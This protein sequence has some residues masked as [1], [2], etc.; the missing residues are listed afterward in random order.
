MTSEDGASYSRGTGN[1][2][3]PKIN[4]SITDLLNQFLK[5]LLSYLQELLLCLLVWM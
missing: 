2:P 3:P 1:V 4:K 5:G